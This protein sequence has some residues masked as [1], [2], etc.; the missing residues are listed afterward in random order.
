MHKRFILINPEAILPSIASDQTQY[1]VWPHNGLLY[2]GTAAEKAGYHVVLWDELVQGPISP[3]NIVEPGDIVGFSLVITGI[4]RGV[5]LAK[6]AKTLGARYCIAGN[7][8]A[9]F[10]SS[11][12]LALEGKPIDAV[13][14]GD[15]ITAITRFFREV[16]TIPLAE[17]SIPGVEVD[18]NHIMRSNT[19]EHLTRELSERRSGV[20]D[21]DDVF[22]VPNLGLFDKTYWE[23]VW[24]NYNENFGHKHPTGQTVRNTLALFS[25]G[26]TRP[27]G[28]DVCS[29]CTIADV[30]NIR[31]P[32]DVHVV[33]LAEM[34]ARFG[35]NTVFNTAD[36]SFEMTPVV[37]M[38]RK[39]HIKWDALTIYGR[40]WGIAREGNQ[41]LME[42]WMSV[43]KDRLLLNV[44]MD[45]GDDG[46]LK[47]GIVKSSADKDGS[48]VEENREATR[49]I[50]QFGAHLHCSLIF[51]NPGE[52]LDTCERSMEYLEW[53]IG[54]LG[55][56]L[57]QAETDRYWLNFGAPASRV[58]FDYD[59]AVLLAS[60]A[61]KTISRDEWFENFVKYKDE[62]VVPEQI[63][64]AWYRFFTKIDID[65]ADE[66]NNKVA[67]RM[68]R[69]TG[70][71][72]G[73]AFVPVS[74]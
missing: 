64:Q 67:K 17:M 24:R 13:F 26:C 18:P 34:Y 14:T 59:Y 11:R 65:I 74:G 35:I 22:I 49:R 3:E 63:Q 58:F 2:V 68:A 53:M 51:G 37:D 31:F 15:S 10:R 12:I 23:T 44:G 70:S 20:R 50:K 62:L 57:D 9:I 38:L 61:G 33:E 28:T 60:Y 66:Y 8:S 32:S 1:R 29:Y 71:I 42:K 19:V 46:L 27:R 73:R 39:H 5:S 25:H 4:E 56:Q 21:D 69:H 45:S 36:S 52:T 16:D 41:T 7:D 48:R 47:N 54:V 40:S 72:R 30:A 55:D 6:E 43:V